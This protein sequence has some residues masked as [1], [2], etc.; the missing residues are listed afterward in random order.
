M[1]D[2][3]DVLSEASKILKTNQFTTT[4]PS[5]KTYLGI[6]PSNEYYFHTW[7]WDSVFHI[8]ALVHANPELAIKNL[9]F[10][11]DS[12][13]ENGHIGHIMY[14][15]EDVSYFPNPTL[16]QTEGK[17]KSGIIS[18]GIIQ[19]PILAIGVRYIYEHLQDDYA[20]EYI[21]S[22]A[23]PSLE[24]YHRY[25][26]TTHDSQNSGLLSIFHPW[27]S[28]SDNAIVFDKP[29]Q[30]ISLADIPKN[31][32]EIVTQN[33]VDDKVGESET[34]PLQEDYYRFLYLVHLGKK[35]GWNYKKLQ[36]QFPFAVK[37]ISVNSLWY[38]ANEALGKFLLEVGR[39]KDAEKY[40]S[41]ALQTQNALIACWDEKEGGFTNVDVHEGNWV[42]EYSESFANFMPFLTGNIPMSQLESLLAKFEDSHQYWTDY[43]IPSVPLNHPQFELKRYWRGPTWPAINY[44]VIVGLG[45]LLNNPS[46]TKEKKERMRRIRN[47]LMEKTLQMIEQEGFYENFSPKKLGNKKNGNG[48]AHFSW[49]AAVSI[50]LQYLSKS[51]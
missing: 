44:F 16:W 30:A 4:S 8:M 50:L 27:S 29:M 9:E 7:F 17:S 11:L 2:R 38:L 46:Y 10:I 14:R 18:S 20:K 6:S 24:K 47:E 3:K 34:R 21:L 22:K 32:L 39:E 41:W 1:S 19:P 28:G 13:W 42:R 26:K 35:A 15:F 45:K 43:P 51:E 12:Q 23:I 25:L 48:F 49:T 33:R 37:D 36:K 40:F 5:N 31:I